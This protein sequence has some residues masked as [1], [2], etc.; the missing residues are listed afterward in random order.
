MHS[1]LGV[2]VTCAFVAYVFLT[3]ADRIQPSSVLVV[4]AIKLRDLNIATFQKS[5][6]F[7]PATDFL[8]KISV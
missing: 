8:A 2:A 7:E 3:T 5:V 4:T 1:L 6:T